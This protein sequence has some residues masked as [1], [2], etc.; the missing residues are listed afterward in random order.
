M[1][2]LVLAYDDNDAELGS[3]FEDSYNQI[4]EKTQN[5]NYL[6][7]TAVPGLNCTKQNITN[8]A[9]ELNVGPFLFVS[10]SHG[11]RKQLV[12]NEAFLDFENSN[13]FTNSLIYTV[14]CSSNFSL[15]KK[16]TDDGG[17]CYVGYYGTSFASYEDFYPSYIE[18]ENH[19]LNEFLRTDKTID[20]TFD[21]MRQLFQAKIY[22]LYDTNEINVAMEFEHNLDNL[23]IRG[24]R[25]L[26]KNDLLI[27]G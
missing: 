26:T 23:A 20:E 19:A 9:Q 12:A 13:H 15:G 21:E 18:C 6:T 1:I 27:G 7:S 22:E 5:L 16:I 10:L 24:N 14:A 2:Q 25:T 8:I 4:S 11:N 17:K 3:Y